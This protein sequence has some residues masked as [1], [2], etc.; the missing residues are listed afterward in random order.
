MGIP[1]IIEDHWRRRGFF[2]I[3]QLAN[4]HF[5]RTGRPLPVALDEVGWRFHNVTEAKVAE[6]R[7]TNPI[8]KSI[9]HRLIR[10]LKLNIQFLFVFDGPHRPRKRNKKGGNSVDYERTRLLVQLL[11][12]LGV[13]T[14]RAPGE[15]EAK[16]ARLQREGGGD[17]NTK[18]LPQCGGLYAHI[19]AKAG[20]GKE[21]C[22]ATCQKGLDIWSERF[23]QFFRNRFKIPE[24]F[25][26]WMHVD[27]YNNPKVSFLEQLHNP[28]ELRNGW[29]LR[30]DEEN[31]R[32]FL[33]ERFNIWTKG[34]LEHVAPLLLIQTLV[35]SPSSQKA[36]PF[37]VELVHRRGNKAAENPFEL[38]IKF[39][40][41][42]VTRVKLDAPPD[43]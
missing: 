23:Q 28:R 25:P 2:P 34:Y 24:G 38:K 29:N 36:N 6:I 30:V 41:T 18:G 1:R 15:V 11:R 10:L 32:T 37:N 42:A 26:R 17:Y 20:V 13:P 39:Q 27:H 21:L 22:A 3:A 33:R 35:S 43:S 14:H 40:P 16:C 8:E 5:I 19:T 12:Y 31:L 4:E 9:F 7:E